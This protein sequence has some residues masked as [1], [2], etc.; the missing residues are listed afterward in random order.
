VSGDE[1]DLVV[2]PTPWVQ[3]DARGRRRVELLIST[4][5]EI[6]AGLQHGEQVAANAPKIDRPQ[7]HPLMRFMANSLTSYTCG[8]FMGS[9][10]SAQDVLRSVNLGPLADRLDALLAKPV[11]DHTLRTFL[12]E[13][14]N[15]TVAHPTFDPKHIMRRVFDLA[16]LHDDEVS[17]QYRDAFFEFMGLAHS[18]HALLRKAY[19]LAAV[20]EDSRSWKPVDSP[21]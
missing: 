15:T 5:S 13:H 8:T 3:L 9:T 4:L 11:G 12:E 14:R 21:H 20:S 1:D 2:S 16:E 18:V 6:E 10:S 7:N 17:D 19:P